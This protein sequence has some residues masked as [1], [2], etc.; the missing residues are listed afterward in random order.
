[1]LRTAKDLE[2]CT[3]EATDG[4]IGSVEDFYFDDDQ[5]VV[6]YIVVK[7]G[8]WFSNRRVLISPLSIRQAGGRAGSWGR[9]PWSRSRTV[10]RSIRTSPC[11]ASMRRVTTTIMVIRTTGVVWAFGERTRTKYDD[12]VAQL[13]GRR[14]GD[15]A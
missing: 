2:R 4:L 1:M 6:R 8:N 12:A 5:W 7:T 10:P 15:R 14:G 3:I 9:S 13:Q 11:S